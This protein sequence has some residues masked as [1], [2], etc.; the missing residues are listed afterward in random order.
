MTTSG[1]HIRRRHGT[2]AMGAAGV[3]SRRSHGTLGFDPRPT[4]PYY[5]SQID[6]E[7]IDVVDL[8]GGIIDGGT[9]IDPGTIPGSAFDPTPPAVPASLTLSSAEVTGSDGTSVVRLRAEITLVAVPDADLFGTYVEVTS[10]PSP[11]WDRPQQIFIPVGQLSGQIEG[12]KGA[13]QYWGRARSVDVV[14]NY[15]AFTAVE[16]HTTVADTAPPP[17]PNPPTVTAGFR[18]F[19]ASWVGGD[20]ADLSY[21]EVRWAQAASP[22]DGDD[23]AWTY[24]QTK[25][26]TVFVG[27]LDAGLLYWVEVRGVDISGN[28]SGWTAGVSVTPNLI[29]APDMGFESISAAAG[30]IADLD[31]DDI[32]TGTLR[33]RDATGFADGILVYG[34][35]SDTI[36]VI[37]INAPDDDGIMRFRDASNENR[38]LIVESAE[39]RFTSD[40]GA[41]DEA[42]FTPD[43]LNASA[44]RF[45]AA[46]GGH[47]LIFNSSYELA[48]FVAASTLRVFTDNTTSGGSDPAWH[49][50][51]R[52]TSPDN[53]T[54]GATSLTAA[55]LAF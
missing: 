17:T 16:T 7:M 37:E 40:G 13:T 26:T 12:V 9:H 11:T 51:F 38:Q 32:E 47:N 46:G 31:A 3:T 14:G 55:T 52:T 30:H 4:D 28:Q 21:Y 23:G 24:M 15:S 53:L 50:N 1:H 49:A 36:P 29:G 39:I 34:P 48:D 33:I 42:A 10:N 5:G 22:P 25:A 27:N 8:P 20:A 43:G 6:V 54:E 19:A 35:A 44:I 41:T 2:S 45:G 18:G